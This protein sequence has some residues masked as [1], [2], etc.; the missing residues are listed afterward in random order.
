MIKEND[1]FLTLKI[2]IIGDTD[3]GKSSIISRYL[4]P[5]DELSKDIKSTNGIAFNKTSIQIENYKILLDIRDISGKE[6]SESKI[7]P[8][9]KDING[10][11]I[12]YDITNETSFKNVENWNTLL[13]KNKLIIPTILVGNKCDLK[14]ERKV[15]D[16]KGKEMA[17][18]LLCPFNETSALTPT[19]NINQI[20]NSI[21]Q[22][23]LDSYKK[24]KEEYK[25]EEKEIE[26]ELNKKK[27]LKLKFQ[28]KYEDNGNCFC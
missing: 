2:A 4:K 21:I 10:C 28:K 22:E 25:K 15:S 20:F 1:S 7:C 9:L 27:A 5:D 6:K 23:R 13:Q 11:L 14:N 24:E 18:K 16:V 12:V 17:Q 8:L 26:K 3:V 19:T